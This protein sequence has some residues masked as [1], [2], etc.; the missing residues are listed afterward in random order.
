MPVDGEE[1]NPA[2][3]TLRGH[4][5]LDYESAA[6]SAMKLLD[7]PWKRFPS[8]MVGWD[9]TARRA[10]GATIYH[11]ATPARYEHWLRAT[12]DS[13]AGVRSEE[14]YLFIL[15]WNEWAE[16]NHLEPDQRYG[17]AFLEA[18]RAVLVDSAPAVGADA[19]A[20][21]QP[22]AYDPLLAEPD[23]P[24]HDRAML[25]E[26][27]ANVAGL[28]AELELPAGRQVVD[29]A[30]QRV[31]AAQ[32]ARPAYPGIDVVPGP[33]S[34]VSS[35]KSTL[36]GIDGIGALVLTDVLQHLAEPQDLL[37]ALAAWSLDHGSPPLLDRRTSC[38]P[39]GHRP[40][41]HVRPIRGE[42]GGWPSRSGEPALSSPRTLCNAFSTARDGASCAGKTCDSLYSEQYDD[43]LR[44]GLPEE[45]VGAL[46][47]SAQAVNPNW[48]VTYFVWA[49]EPCPVD[50][51]PSS[52][53]EA[54]A[55]LEPP[56]A[57][58]HQS[59]GLGSGR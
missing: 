54:V 55:P 14:N 23:A 20:P 28:L 50:M 16:G 46:Q 26:A 31:D 8:V 45:L 52:Y 35:L 39:R 3:E 22:T 30:E 37:T 40:A 53:G 4:R 13:V 49:L 7:V 41:G 59:E 21:G 44:D 57:R 19:S 36:D 47:A 24:R 51:A 6:E 27:A 42:P 58:V 12:A 1:L 5:L 32:P 38:R 9:N 25:D 34:D 48:A 11:G 43:G 33:F 56:T 18:T 29:L 2:L 15:A 10:K 17:R